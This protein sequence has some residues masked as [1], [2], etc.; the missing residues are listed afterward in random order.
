M[1]VRFLLSRGVRGFFVV[2][3]AVRVGRIYKTIVHTTKGHS[4]FV[5]VESASLIFSRFLS[6][7][8]HADGLADTNTVCSTRR[9]PSLKRASHTT[10]ELRMRRVLMSCFFVLAART[11][12]STD[13][14]INA[15]T[16]C[17][18]DGNRSWKAVAKE[19]K[20]HILVKPV[21]HRQCREPQ[22]EK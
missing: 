19:V 17:Y 1:A 10:E 7:F 21:S 20:E 16:T 4:L 6:V 18:T 2:V 3:L 8:S 14:C 22:G 5:C 9:T 12:H 15:G 11:I 13:R